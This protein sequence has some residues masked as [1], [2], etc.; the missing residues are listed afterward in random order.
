MA[1]QEATP[2]QS[3]AVK[4]ELRFAVT[5]NGGVSLA[6]YIG[7]V[8]QELN[9]V[10]KAYPV[11]ALDPT[12]AVQR[13][14]SGPHPY[15]SL[16]DLL[17][18]TPPVIDVITGTSAGGINA[19]ALA[20]AQANVNGDIAMLKPL[21]LQDA[22]IEAML[23]KP[24]QKSAPSLMKGDE[25]FL[26]LL[27]QAFRQMTE[28]GYIRAQRDIDLTIP[29]TLLTPWNE[30]SRDE[31]GTRLVE[32]EFAG[33]F[34]FPGPEN[35][36]EERVDQ[37]SEEKIK[38]TAQALALAARASAGF[39]VA[40]EPTFIPVN[41]NSHTDRPDMAAF[42]NW[43]PKTGE[44][45]S[46]YAVDGGV[47]NN[48]PTRPALAGIQRREAS[49]M[50]VRRVLVLVHPHALDASTVCDTADETAKPPTLLKAIQGVAKAATSVGSKSYVDEIDASNR[51]ALRWRDGRT[52]ALE[53]FASWA[54]LQTFLDS[55]PGHAWKLFRSMRIQRNAYIMANAVRR[56]DDLRLVRLADNARRFLEKKDDTVGLP[57]LSKEPPAQVPVSHRVWPWGVAL[58]TGVMGL[59]SDLLR[60]LNRRIPRENTA[61][62]ETVSKVWSAVINDQIKIDTLGEQ[63]EKAASMAARDSG[64]GLYERFNAYLD[65][66]RNQL[67]PDLAETPG[68]STQAGLGT[69]VTA[70]QGPD[71]WVGAIVAD[72]VSSSVREFFTKV[73]KELPDQFADR[74]I[75]GKLGKELFK[76]VQNADDLLQR[77]LSVEVVSYLVSENADP[78]FE[79]RN[80]YIELV[81][82]SAQVP[83]HFAEGFNSDDKLAGMSLGRFGAFIKRSWRANDWIWGRLDAAKTIMLVLLTSE[84]IR[85]LAKANRDKDEWDQAFAAQIVDAIGRNAFGNASTYDA[86]KGR[87][88][89][90]LC[91]A[92][93]GEVW[94]VLQ[95]RKAGPLPFLASLAA[96]GP[97]MA[98][99]Y[100]EMPSLR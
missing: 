64:G 95:N 15:R 67:M 62:Q 7:G 89:F 96:Y 65:V 85:R 59:M 68:S 44:P 11:P 57:H 54:D 49:G 97:Q 45:A 74:V 13:P 41:D 18:Y 4:Q 92:A 98:I 51:R 1:S 16:L 27:Q 20:V 63:L 58:A 26:P 82:L 2:I 29:T 42:A 37:F 25:Y 90:D 28:H 8:A 35:S 19:A 66:Y 34:N 70:E 86:L 93:N 48:T 39:P 38:D 76:D 56:E 73:V 50:I 99:A 32:G 80:D 6:V 17:G 9:S 72:Y 21:W 87:Q 75:P 94:S 53:R 46:R 31:L 10:T 81:Q 47:L 43:T 77:L 36:N 52:V 24:F 23:R 61:F 88:L 5:M 91:Q 22:Q 60:E 83:Q 100:E 14:D 71:D 69:A 40:F 55:T 33:L 3:P 79:E 30:R 78:G 12:V 84:A